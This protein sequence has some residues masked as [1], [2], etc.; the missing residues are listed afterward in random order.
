MEKTF[1]AWYK[2]EFGQP[3]SE[4]Q[5]SRL[6]TLE[7]AQFKVNH[8][9]TFVGP[10]VESLNKEDA[11]V[12]V[13]IRPL[14][15]RRFIRE[16]SSEN[17]VS[18]WEV[19]KELRQLGI[20]DPEKV[21]EVEKK[22]KENIV[23]VGCVHGGDEKFMERLW[24]IAAD[25]P[26]YLICMGD[27]IGTRTFEELQR[28]FYN[29][30]NNHSKNEL[31]KV[32]PDATDEEILNYVG[33]NPPEPGL[34]L[35]EGYKHLFRYEQELLGFSQEE[36]EEKVNSL[37]DQQ[38]AQEIRRLAKFVHYGHYASNLPEKTKEKLAS[39]LRENAQKI[40]EVAK[41]IQ[42]K[43]T[44]VYM[45][46]GNWDARAPI[47]F[48]PG[49][50]EAI[51]LSKE[52]RLFNPVDFVNREGVPFYD[53]LTTLETETTFQILAPFDGIIGAPQM[54]EEDLGNLKKLVE[55]ARNAKKT[56]VF[57]GHGEP[58]WQIHNLFFKG[59][60]P[61]GEHQQLIEGYQRLL[62][63][64]L[65]DEIIYDHMHDLIL[66]EER[67][68]VDPNFKYLVE[69]IDGEIR[70][71]EEAERIG[72]GEKQALATYVPFRETA[73]LKTQKKERARKI[74]GLGGK[75]KPIKTIITRS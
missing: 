12:K 67:K 68:P 46:E 28:R 38:I 21:K 52:K 30:V 10:D 51:P 14:A 69:V 6:N 32:K 7:R 54:S 70:L 66:N 4:A 64:I 1:E 25:P 2:P 22:Y 39:G 59:A 16:V 55:K 11:K 9:E 42:E 61:R 62:P 47:D 33:S 57:V 37:I 56:V 19:V 45:I 49:E 3:L 60:Q 50:P 71:M 5:L 20:K 43:G 53:K 75:R 63:K 35:K 34:T 31:F 41:A 73:I 15:L 13:M 40:L 8:W 24:E 48:V 23:Y 74:E 18:P 44:R 72:Q 58:N 65:P 36:I 29:Y 26:D 17:H 27:L